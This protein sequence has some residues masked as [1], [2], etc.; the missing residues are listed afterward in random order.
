VLYSDLNDND[1]VVKFN[2]IISLPSAKQA[3]AEG[4]SLPISSTKLKMWDDIS[5]DVLQSLMRASFEQNEDAA[6]ALVDTGDK[7]IT[8]DNAKG[9]S[10]DDRFAPALTQIRQELIDG[11][12]A[13]NTVKQQ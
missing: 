7:I 4:R 6:Q 8:H 10:L 1:K 2:H 11:G 3:R 13:P 12:H 5:T 9:E